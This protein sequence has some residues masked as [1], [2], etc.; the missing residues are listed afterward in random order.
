MRRGQPDPGEV[1]RSVIRIA[2]VGCHHGDATSRA[3]PGRGDRAKVAVRKRQARHPEVIPL[4]PSSDG[5]E[6]NEVPADYE[7]QDRARH[8][9]QA[10]QPLAGRVD[11]Y[12]PANLLG[13]HERAVPKG[14]PLIAGTSYQADDEVLRFQGNNITPATVVLIALLLISGSQFTLF[15]MWFD[16]ES[17][18]DLR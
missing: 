3:L 14:G 8:R 18:K 15:A 2:R 16:M 9:E 6:Q 4:G 17:N 5:P 10:R 11:H 1:G 12:G 13:Q 7:Q